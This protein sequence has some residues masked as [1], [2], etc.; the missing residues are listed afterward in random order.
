MELKF[1]AL[2]Y[3]INAQKVKPFNIFQNVCFAEAVERKIKQYLADPEHYEYQ[4]YHGIVSNS[5]YGEEA[6]KKDIDISLRNEFWSRVQNEMRVGDKIEQNPNNLTATD[7]YEQCVM[8][9][10]V[11]FDYIL[12]SYKEELGC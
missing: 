5:I 7:V 10:D 4:D 3:D 6:I 11:L 9:F 8:N 1:Y 2:R 12:C